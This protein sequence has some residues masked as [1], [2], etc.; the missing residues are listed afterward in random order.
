MA[1]TTTTTTKTQKRYTREHVQFCQQAI[2]NKHKKQ[3][4]EFECKYLETRKGQLRSNNNT[5]KGLPGPKEL[6]ANAQN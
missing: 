2:G 6:R 1:A 5:R 3:P 4:I